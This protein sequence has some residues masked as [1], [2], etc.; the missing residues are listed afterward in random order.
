MRP[1]GHRFRCKSIF[2]WCIAATSCGGTRQW[3]F[4]LARGRLAFHTEN[5]RKWQFEQHALLSASDHEAMAGSGR[6]R[7]AGP[8]P[9]DRLLRGKRPDTPHAPRRGPVPRQPVQRQLSAILV[10]ASSAIGSAVPSCGHLCPPQDVGEDG[11]V[12]RFDRA[13]SSQESLAPAT[14]NLA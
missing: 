13:S 8:P 11:G 4:L 14:D 7:R 10:A 2:R 12:G 3:G 1:A 9:T 5:F 6:D